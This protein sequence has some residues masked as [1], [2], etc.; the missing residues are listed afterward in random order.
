M[1]VWRPIP[2]FNEKYWASTEG[3]IRSHAKKVNLKNKRGTKC[4]IVQYFTLMM[5]LFKESNGYLRVTLNGKKT[6]VHRLILL[7]FIGHPDKISPHVA[8]LNGI[9]SD[10]RLKNLKWCSA[11]ENTYHKI[12]HG[13]H[14]RGEK[15]V[16][17]KFT[18]LGYV[19]IKNKKSDG[20]S[21]IKTAKYFGC[22]KMVVLDIWKNRPWV[23]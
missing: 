10:N 18:D 5:K 22:S 2:G 14:G 17:S 15:N 9:R 6:S 16:N 3:R 7:T 13:T 21:S 8:H 19:A 11:K 12:A 23:A 4:I 20:W 1:E